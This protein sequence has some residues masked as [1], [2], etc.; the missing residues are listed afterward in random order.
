MKKLLMRLMIGLI[1]GYQYAISPH[2]PPSCR[3]TPTCSTY[4]LTAIEK[5]GPFKGTWLAIKRILR[6]HP[7]HPGGYDPV[8]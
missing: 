6:C 3:Y 4:A 8:P 2:F 1:K 7:F 5:Y